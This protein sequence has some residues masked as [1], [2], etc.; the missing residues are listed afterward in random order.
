METL[1]NI[2]LGSMENIAV[3]MRDGRSQGERH[4]A[5]F[6]A[7]HEHPGKSLHWSGFTGRDDREVVCPALPPNHMPG[8]K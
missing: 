2:F 5:C 6:P 1:E 7:S 3:R 4:L 8:A